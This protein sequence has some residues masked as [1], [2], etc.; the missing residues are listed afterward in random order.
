MELAHKVTATHQKQTKHHQLVVEAS[1]PEVIGQWD[2]VRLEQVLDNLISNS[3]KYSPDG[4]EIK[5]T[6]G[7]QKKTGGDAGAGKQHDPNN[8]MEAV[9]TIKDY[10]IGIPAA[11]IP[12]IFDWYRRGANV[13]DLIAGTGVGLAGVR[14]IVE[15]HGGRISVE[16]IENEG[17]TFTLV[18]PLN[19]W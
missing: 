2:P 5:I 1:Q 14:Q 10:G 8:A 16:S 17:A 18:L 13:S 19:W 3:I 7:R 12:H 6:V 11:D 9:L 15:Q 4:G